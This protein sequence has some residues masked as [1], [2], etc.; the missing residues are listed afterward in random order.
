MHFE[1]HQ[2]EENSNR[3]CLKASVAIPTVFLQSRPKEYVQNVCFVLFLTN[4]DASPLL[5]LLRVLKQLEACNIEKDNEEKQQE[6]WKKLGPLLIESALQ[7]MRIKKKTELL[8]ITEKNN[9][10]L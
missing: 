1:G 6:V 10:A 2:W 5:K 3:K 8:H 4:Q 9:K 7:K